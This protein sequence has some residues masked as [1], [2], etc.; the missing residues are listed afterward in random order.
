MWFVY[1]LECSD[2]SLY[3]GSSNNL[4]K[5][6][7]EHKKGKGGHY[8]RSHKPIRIVYKEKLKTKSQALKREDEIKKLKRAEKIKNL[9]LNSA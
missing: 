8:T 3:T 6:F 7:L 5:R 9:N 1:I 2:G 4:E